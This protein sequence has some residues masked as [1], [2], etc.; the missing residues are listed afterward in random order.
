[1]VLKFGINIFQIK[2]PI[3]TLLEGSQEKI[4]YHSKLLKS[5]IITYMSDFGI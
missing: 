4:K 3:S 1:M 2:S 5:S